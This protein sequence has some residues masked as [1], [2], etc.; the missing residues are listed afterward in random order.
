M[1]GY[2]DTL[3]LLSKSI[4]TLFKKEISYFDTDDL[5]TSL[6][7]IDD[8]IN[9]IKDYQTKTMMKDLTESKTLKGFYTLFI[10]EAE[11]VKYIIEIGSVMNEQTFQYI[12]SKQSQNDLIIRRKQVRRGLNGYRSDF[13]E[14]NRIV[15]LTRLYKPD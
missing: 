3:I 15:C 4:S 11:Q 12:I 10:L 6:A 9:K 8:C 5:N 14:N 1:T 7:F 2:K 13:N